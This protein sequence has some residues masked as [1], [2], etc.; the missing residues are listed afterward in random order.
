M[1]QDAGVSSLS[2][3]IFNCDETGFVTDPKT[4][5]VLDEK[6]AAR[7]TQSKGGSGREQVTCVTF[8]YHAKCTEIPE[9]ADIEAMDWICENCLQLM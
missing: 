3:Q 5:V 8:W 2:S 9:E 4:Q 7:V 6:G 1:L